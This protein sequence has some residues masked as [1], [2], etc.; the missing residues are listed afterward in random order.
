MISQNI[1]PR[2]EE[3]DYQYWAVSESNLGTE[4]GTSPG[5]KEPLTG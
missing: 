3:G 2:K 1:P 4:I 5:I